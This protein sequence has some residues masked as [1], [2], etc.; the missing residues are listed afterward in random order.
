MSPIVY[1]AAAIL[2]F[3]IL[4]FVVDEVKSAM[5]KNNIS[6]K[7]SRRLEE[8][9]TYYSGLLTEWQ[10]RLTPTELACGTTSQSSNLVYAYFSYFI[11]IGTV[12]IIDEDILAV[13]SRDNLTE[14]EQRVLAFLDTAG[15]PEGVTDD[16]IRMEELCHNIEKGKVDLVSFEQVIRAAAGQ[17]VAKNLRNE[18]DKKNLVSALTELHSYYVFSMAKKANAEELS[19]FSL[20]YMLV[21]SAKHSNNPYTELGQ[22]EE[23]TSEKQR[24]RIRSK[25]FQAARS[26]YE[27]NRGGSGCAFGCGGCGGD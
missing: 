4:R 23:R 1:I 13:V 20:L 9:P 16:L 11:A 5:K 14:E 6:K 22:Q 10:E 21:Y 18:E 25:L 26:R 24:Y 8:D 19:G 2:L 17:K 7:V 27:A 3:I 15:V 12:R